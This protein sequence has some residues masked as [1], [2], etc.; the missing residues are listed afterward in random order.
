MTSHPDFGG[1]AVLGP[2]FVASSSSDD[3]NGHGTHVAGSVGGSHFGAAKNVS[4]TAVRVLDCRG[5]GSA[6]TIIAGLD[7]VAANHAPLSVANLSLS[8]AYSAALN[9]AVTNTVATGVTVVVAAG[10]NGIPPDACNYSPGSAA[11]A[12]TVGASARTSTPTDVMG[13]FSDYGNCVDLFAPGAQI[14][15]DWIGSYVTWMLDGTS[16]AAAF[17]SGAAAMYLSAHPSATPSE[18]S[19]A[20]IGNATTGALSLVGSG[21]PNRLLYT[22][23]GSDI[24]PPPPP[25]NAKPT[26]SFTA[27]C[28]KAVC[29]FDASKSTDDIGV[30]SYAWSFGDNTSGSG[31][32][33]SHTYTGKGKYSVVVTLT[34]TDAGGLT[35][36][37]QQ[38]L[39]ISN[40]GK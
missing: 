9:Q 19:A 26:A 16:S 28:V 15:S 33:A 32:L 38:K 22:G 40:N 7:W 4:L 14:V 24:P 23:N 5:S 25:T 31:A 8:G 27:S 30:V 11:S 36:S 18:V 12:I 13:S 6:S 34:V 21:S 10:D 3:C 20:L 35:G 29:K 1:R 2:D 17:T 37:M 39:N